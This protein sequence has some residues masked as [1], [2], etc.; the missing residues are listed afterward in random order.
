MCCMNPSNTEETHAGGTGR[1]RASERLLKRHELAARLAMSSRGIA[2]LTRKRM[3]PV[4][5]L[6]R[7]CVRYDFAKVKAAIDRFEIKEVR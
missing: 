1:E 7:K 2:E 5:R 3:I 6:G 4:I